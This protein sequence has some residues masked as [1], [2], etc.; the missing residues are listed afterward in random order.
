MQQNTV[1]RTPISISLGAIAGAISRYYFGLWFT[2]LF[3]TE[4]PYIGL[5][6]DL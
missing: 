5:I 1:I 4:F 3:G 6:F 2:Q